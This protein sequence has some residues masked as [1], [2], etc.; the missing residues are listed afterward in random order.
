V[1]FRRIPLGSKLEIAAGTS[2]FFIPL[3]AALISML[4]SVYKET[5]PGLTR[6]LIEV[7]PVENQRSEISPRR[8]HLQRVARL[9]L[10]TGTVLV[11]LRAVL[12]LLHH[13]RRETVSGVLELLAA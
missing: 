8:R 5:V 4:W 9:L 12:A 3:F 13:F 7:R 1:T 10:L 11:L 6:S 2:S